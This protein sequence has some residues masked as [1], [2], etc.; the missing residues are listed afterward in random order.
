ML[1]ED[2]RNNMHE[3]KKQKDVLKSNLL[4]TL[5]AEMFTLS[6]SGKELT[7]EDSVKIVKKFIKN[8]DETLALDIPEEAKK[9]YL[10]EKQILMGYL[11][12]QLSA[13]DIEMTVSQ[14]VGEG[15]V[16]KDIMVHFKENFAGRYD[17]KTVSD[18]AKLK[19]AK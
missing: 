9:K 11:P 12:S 18:I 16:M 13:E 6:K 17:G 15:K 19:L 5:Y 1:I 10:A 14:L 3:A 8:C 2:V 7:D 4:S